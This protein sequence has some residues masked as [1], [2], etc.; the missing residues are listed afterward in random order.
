L[1]FR[2]AGVTVPAQVA[3]NAV[4]IGAMLVLGLALDARRAA[5]AAP[6]QGEMTPDAPRP[7]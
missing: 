5:R 4:G 3:V 1:I 6:K 2:T 7:A